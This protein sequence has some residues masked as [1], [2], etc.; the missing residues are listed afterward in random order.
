MNK[1]Q[2]WL[3]L[4]K[5]LNNAVFIEVVVWILVIGVLFG[6]TYTFFYYKF[7]KPN[8]YTIVF[9]D[10][11]GLIKGSPVRFMGLVVGHVRKL[12]YHKDSIETEIIV[13]KK[14]VQIPSGSIASV[15]FSGIAGS[16]SIEIM[17]PKENL[18]DIGI[19]SKPTLRI[20]D[21]MDEYAGIGKIFASLKDF[22][23]ALNQDNISKIFGAV[24]TAS[25]SLKKIDTEI[26]DTN[27]KQPE[28][29]KKL[30]NIINSEKKLEKTL[31]KANKHAKKIGSYFKK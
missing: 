23:D 26:D 2:K 29:N 19:I 30:D 9:N 24:K 25:S 31:D 3:E 6:A 22:V 14:G 17:P 28:I 4:K 16:K 10:T 27:T 11:D 12:T 20:G 1:K 15:E 21:V 18:S 13:T 8:L 5:R 7:I